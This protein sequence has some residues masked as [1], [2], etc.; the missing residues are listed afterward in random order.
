MGLDLIYSTYIYIGISEHV[1]TIIW[2]TSIHSRNKWFH[3]WQCIIVNL[4]IGA[5]FC[6]RGNE[7]RIFQH[8]MQLQTFSFLQKALVVLHLWLHKIKIVFREIKGSLQLIGNS[9]YSNH[10]ILYSFLT[11]LSWWVLFCAL[12]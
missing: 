5:K 4:P 7:N 2:E 6:K 8:R 10:Y 3:L 12:L 1:N 9:G 11:R